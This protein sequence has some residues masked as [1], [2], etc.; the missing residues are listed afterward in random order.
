MSPI[1]ADNASAGVSR[2]VR[3][4]RCAYPNSVSSRSLRFSLGSWMSVVYAA[5][6]ALRDPSERTRGRQCIVSRNGAAVHAACDWTPASQRAC[7]ETGIASPERRYWT[8]IQLARVFEIR[9]RPPEARVGGT[10][11]KIPWPP[12][13]RFHVDR[14]EAGQR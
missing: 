10:A 6:A 3:W 14:L 5:S 4:L 7:D 8:L 2:V 9:K 1:Q 12:S 11:E 13:C